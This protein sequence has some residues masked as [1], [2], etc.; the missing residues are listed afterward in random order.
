MDSWNVDLF[1]AI[2]GPAVPASWVLHLAMACAEGLVYVGALLAAGLWMWGAPHRRGGL[3]AVGGGLLLAFAIST[4]IGQFWYHLRPFVAGIGHALMP[5][6]AET[7]FPSDHGTFLFTLALG[8][9][10]TGA[11]RRWGAV[12]LALGVATAWARVYLGVHWP[13]DMAGSFILASV[14]AMFAVIVRPLADAH[15]AP[16]IE[17]FYH[18]ILDTLR[19]PLVMFPRRNSSA[20]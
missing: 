13:L 4:A 3:V 15:L 19:L 16:L 14:C 8:L 20:R 5:H 17:R 1:L 2:N 9:I 11:A 18:W 10:A 12:V 7:S 6:N